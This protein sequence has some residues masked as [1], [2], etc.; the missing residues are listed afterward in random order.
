MTTRYDDPTFTQM[1]CWGVFGV[2]LVVLLL[3]SLV[4]AVS[5]AFS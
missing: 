4:A 2:I 1:L 3:Y 5:Y